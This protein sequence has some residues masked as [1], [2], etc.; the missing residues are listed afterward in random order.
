MLTETRWYCH[1]ADLIRLMRVEDYGTFIQLIIGFVLAGGRDAWY[2]ATTILILA[3]C[4]YGGLYAL[5]DAHDAEVD[6]FHPIKSSRPV[7]AGRVD[8]VFAFTLGIGL[9]FLGL[10][11]AMLFDL[12]VLILA[13]L[14]VTI[15][16]AYTFRL[17]TVPYVEIV[18][19]TITHPLRFAAGLWLAGGMMDWSLLIVWSLAAFA[20]ATLKRIKEMREVG[21]TVRPVLRYYN[22][23]NLRQLI[24][25]SLGLLAGMWPFT[26]GYGFILTG[27]WIALILTAVVGYFHIPLIRKLV[28]YAWR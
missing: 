23:I 6:R 15:N 1:P 28:E 7:A 18:A 4:I 25:I 27:I 5:N 24:M 14:F 19:N 11:A 12:K 16:L 8:L 9:I 21:V 26:N 20:I 13:L 22:E 2:L 10:G 3:P 17:K